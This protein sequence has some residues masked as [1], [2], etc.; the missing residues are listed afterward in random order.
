MIILLWTSSIPKMVPFCYENPV[1]LTKES[2][3]KIRKN[4]DKHIPPACNVPGPHKNEVGLGFWVEWG[5]CQQL[6]SPSLSPLW[7]AI[8]PSPPMMNQIFANMVKQADWRFCESWLPQHFWFHLDARIGQVI[9]QGPTEG[10][11]KLWKIWKMRNIIK[12]QKYLES[13]GSV[14]VS[15][16]KN[17]TRNNKWVSPL[18]LVEVTI[19]RDISLV[20]IQ[21][22]RG[23]QKKK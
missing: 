1:D 17:I 16:L 11:W 14:M 3:K 10:W 21:I 7:A 4:D 19:D 20:I 22:S 8:L 5:A 18:A 2:P 12:N 15:P 6:D 23:A 13:D 9:Y